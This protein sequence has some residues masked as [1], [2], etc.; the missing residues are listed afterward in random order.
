MGQ[1]V[2]ADPDALELRLYQGPSNGF[3]A[4]HFRSIGGANERCGMVLPHPYFNQ[5]ET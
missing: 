4:L 2:P 3:A 5:F 1:P